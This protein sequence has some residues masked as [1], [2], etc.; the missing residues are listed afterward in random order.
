MRSSKKMRCGVV[1]TEASQSL[2]RLVV[3]LGYCIASSEAR[4]HL[5]M[6]VR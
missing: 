5:M 2:E 6:N 3:D 1:R 4:S